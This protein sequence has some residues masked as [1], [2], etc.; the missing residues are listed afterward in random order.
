MQD[1]YSQSQADVWAPP[2]AQGLQCHS[3][4]HSPQV[5]PSGTELLH[6]HHEPVPADGIYTQRE[7]AIHG[8]AIDTKRRIVAPAAGT[9]RTQQHCRETLGLHGGHRGQVIHGDFINTD[10][11]VKSLETTKVTKKKR[12]LL[13]QHSYVTKPS[14]PYSYR[15]LMAIHC[16]T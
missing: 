11:T 3:S 2:W 5:L 7:P 1:L 15:L 14:V 16:T 12:S 6:K 13:G 9:L 8:A 10:Y 4:S